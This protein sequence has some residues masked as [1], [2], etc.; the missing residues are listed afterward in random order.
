VQ[1]D[2][3]HQLRN[4]VLLIETKD[5]SGII[6]YSKNEFNFLTNFVL[7]NK[8]NPDEREFMDFKE[9]SLFINKPVKKNLIL[10]RLLTNDEELDPFSSKL[11]FFIKLHDKIEIV[12]FDPIFIFKDIQNLDISLPEN[13]F[14]TKIQQVGYV[15]KSVQDENIIFEEKFSINMSEDEAK[16]QNDAE[17]AKSMLEINSN[18]IFD[19]KKEKSIQAKQNEPIDENFYSLEKNDKVNSTS[20]TKKGSG[21]FSR[22]KTKNKVDEHKDGSGSLNMFR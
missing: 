10:Y 13:E 2:G 11:G 19:Q 17:L 22:V 21:F 20:G 9:V 4:N 1:S 8:N 5:N 16:N 14:K 18:I 6:V 3:L 15:T 7:V 12:Y